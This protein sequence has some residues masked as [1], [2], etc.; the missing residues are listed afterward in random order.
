M[1]DFSRDKTVQA[2][3]AKMAAPMAPT[4]AEFAMTLAADEA[5]DV[6]VGEVDGLE[7]PAVVVPVLVGGLVVVLRVVPLVAVVVTPGAVVVVVPVPVEVLALVEP[8]ALL[9]RQP[10]SEEVPTVKGAVCETAPVESRKVSPREVPAG[11]L[12]IHVR[13]VPFC[14]PKSVRG[15]ALG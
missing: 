15:L 14:L 6:P 3:R 8:P 10:V 12:T 13:E 1:R 2:K 5:D 11:W 4:I 9:V 7:P